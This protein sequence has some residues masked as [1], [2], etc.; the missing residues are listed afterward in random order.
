MREYPKGGLIGKSIHLGRAVARLRIPLYAA[1]A[2]YFIILAFFPCLLLLLGLLRFTPLEVEWLSELLGGI[3]PAAFLEDAEILIL[4]TYDDASSALLGI[5]VLTALWSSSRGLYG[6]LTGLNA[7]YR[8]RESR[9]WLHTRLIST[10][11]TA[12]FLLVLLLTLTLHVFASGLLEVLQRSAHP[13]VRFVT[14][15][16]DFRFFLLLLVQTLVF[17]LMFMVLPNQRN[18]F[19]SSL[20]GALLASCG[21]LIFSNL[22]SVYMEHFAALHLYGS[23]SALAL[24]MLWLYCCISIVFYGGAL[25]VLLEKG[26]HI[27]ES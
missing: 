3:L 7:I 6:V 4:T 23:L 26:I 8:V 9:S 10:V 22:F 21:W 13:F 1:N 12:A 5:S 18:S 17:S 2:S 25:N 16:I 11:Y 20:P 27:T 19:R 15:W 24:G 14:A